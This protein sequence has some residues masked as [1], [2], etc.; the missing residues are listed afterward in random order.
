MKLKDLVLQPGDEKPVPFSFRTRDFAPRQIP[1]YLTHTTPETIRIVN[2]N[3][4]RAPLY[5]GQIKGTGPRYCPS[6]EVKVKK[7]PDKTRHQIFLEP[8]GYV[9]D[10]VYVNGFSTSLPADV[11]EAALRTV[12][13]LEDVQIIRF[14]YAV[15]YDFFPPY[16]IKP[17]METKKI[18]SL[19]FVGQIN[20]TSGYEEAAGQGLLAGI[21]A[22]LSLQGK[23]PFVPG[24]DEAYLGVMSSDLT[25]MT[26]IS[27]PYRLFTSR[28][29]YRLLLR[30]DNADFRLM[31]Y[32]EKF[33]L[34]SK[35]IYGK[36]C[37]QRRAIAKEIERLKTTFI[38]L[39]PVCSATLSGSRSETVSLAKYL[40]R[41]E[42]S[43]RDL[44]KIEAQKVVGSATLSGSPE[45]RV[46]EAVEI[47][48]KYEG[49]LAQDRALAEKMDRDF[50]TRIPKRFDY[51]KI[52][53]LSAEGREKLKKVRPDSL[54]EARRIDGLR[55]SDLTLLFLRLH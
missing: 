39:P 38:S 18:Q 45:E 52:P 33:G 42:V 23:E 4:D 43:Y 32:G 48:I 30:S 11:Q 55:A 5:T 54:K 27:E 28:A 2:E 49:Y 7:F 37:Q 51:N 36:M 19:Y 10:E 12:P 20:G 44:E 34:I 41:P 17:T 50:K 47:E 6:L 21:N 15:E 3:I 24:R 35:D 29:E 31:D 26:E 8:E 1:C 53:G 25:T 40:R 14:G 46:K 13:G 16:Q 9:T 22:G